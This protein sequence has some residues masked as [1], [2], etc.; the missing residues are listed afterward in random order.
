MGA[1]AKMRGR[2]KRVGRCSS[3]GHGQGCVVTQEIREASVDRAQ[4]KREAAS[5]I[6][7]EASWAAIQDACFLVESGVIPS[8]AYTLPRTIACTECDGTMERDGTT[9]SCGCGT[10][11]DR[12]PPRA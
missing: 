12:L 3:P 4:E 5:E 8:R 9:F 10:R 2:L 1:D 7:R 6:S 11:L